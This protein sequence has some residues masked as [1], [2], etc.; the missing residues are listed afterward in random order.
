MALVACQVTMERKYHW[1]LYLRADES[2]MQALTPKIAERAERS[3]RIGPA[4]E[5]VWGCSG[6]V[7]TIITATHSSNAPAPSPLPIAFSGGGGGV[8]VVAAA[9]WR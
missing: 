3:P 7:P 6:A 2:L 1:L 5:I 8:A 9:R 4:F